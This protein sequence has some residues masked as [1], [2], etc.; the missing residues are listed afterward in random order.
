MMITKN[1]LKIDGNLKAKEVKDKI[2]ATIKLTTANPKN[3]FFPAAS[4]SWQ[5]QASKYP[6]GKPASKMIA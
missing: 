2:T 3:H 4:S 6:A 5:S 1:K